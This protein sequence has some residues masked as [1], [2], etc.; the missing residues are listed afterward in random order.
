MSVA[1]FI[2]EPTGTCRLSLRRFRYGQD[3]EAHRHDASAVIDENAPETPAG[4]DGTRPVTDYRIPRDD[5]RWPAHCECG[6]PFQGDDEWQVNELSWYEG[7]G[8]HFAWGTGSWDGPP[9]AMIRAPW[10]GGSD[11][12]PA[13]I[14]FLPNGTWWCTRDRSA[15]DGNQLG[16]QWSVS[17]TP[18][19]ITVH[20]S[21]DD[22]NPDR[23]W[24]GWIR[25]GQIDPA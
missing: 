23:P 15:G 4:P 16:P 21:I 12:L 11:G 18:P 6:E 3:G 10:R 7:G 14:V 8:Q 19:R 2:A 25:D 24:H 17:G 13:W 9:G 22:R 5:P 20:P 1:L